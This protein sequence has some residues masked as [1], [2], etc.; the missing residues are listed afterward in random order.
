[1][2]VASG[3][4]AATMLLKCMFPLLLRPQVPN[5][6]FDSPCCAATYPQEEPRDVGQIRHLPGSLLYGRRRFLTTYHRLTLRSPLR[7]QKETPFHY[8]R[9]FDYR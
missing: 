4:I 1:M 9:R 2:L 5:W 8:L 6:M 7:R 3:V